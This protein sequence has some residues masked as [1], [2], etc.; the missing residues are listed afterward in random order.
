M[1]VAI[2][3][4]LGSEGGLKARQISNKLD[5]ERKPVSAFLHGNLDDYEQDD[6]YGW[7]LVGAGDIEVSLPSGWV[8]ANAF[9]HHLRAAVSGCAV[10]SLLLT[11]DEG[12]KL[13]FDAIARVLAVANQ[14]IAA[15]QSVSLDFTASAPTRHY[16]NRAGFFDHLDS[17]VAV[18]P[19]R[20]KRSAAQTYQ[21]QSEALVELA[22]VSLDS[23]NSALVEDLCE[24]FVAQSSK[25][26]LNAIV[27]MF[28]ELV[29]NVREHS[30]AR[31][32]FA[33]FQ[34]YGGRRP[35]IQTV[36]SD[37]GAGIATTLR[38]T[39]AEHHSRLFSMFG[40]QSVDT[41]LSLVL[42]A[43]RDGEVSRRGKGK[44]L[45]LKSSHQQS[46][47]FDATFSVRQE[48]FSL[49]FA[50]EGDD[51]VLKQRELDLFPLRGTHIC[52]DFFLA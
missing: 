17:D 5:L 37:D 39:L 11:F 2:D 22:S 20:P 47:K 34:K 10:A 9:E 40:A 42:T 13:M 48:E 46:R 1:K 33:G 16:L 32:G 49:V 18:L 3:R 8:S 38:T 35:H 27:T 4:L 14:T 21:G 19:K 52:F 6:N 31:T 44:G 7:W 26:Y 12:C 36:V 29:D 15:G 45:G 23:D 51:L 30:E 41:D 25:D 43:I 24:K 28:G 50:Y